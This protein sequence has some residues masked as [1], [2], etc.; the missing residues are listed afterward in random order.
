MADG[1]KE[2]ELADEA[3]DQVSGGSDMR[4]DP[5]ANGKCEDC[6]TIL[7][8]TFYGYLCKNCGATYDQNHKK[9]SSGNKEI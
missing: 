7:T 4:D 5:M 1:I 3:L 6:P 8:K 9:L 2:R